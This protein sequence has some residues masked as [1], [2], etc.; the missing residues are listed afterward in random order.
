MTNKE[1]KRKYLNVLNDMCSICTTCH[2][3]YITFI[4]SDEPEYVYMSI[5]HECNKVLY[6]RDGFMWGT[7][8]QL[9]G[10]NNE[11]R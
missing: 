9:E 4:P 6:S 11:C 2:K 5:C 1:S 8:E 3:G 10:E 7:I